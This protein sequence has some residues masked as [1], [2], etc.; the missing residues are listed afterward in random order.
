MTDLATQFHDSVVVQ[1][2]EFIKSERFSEAIAF[3]T[4]ALAREPADAEL[5]Y[6][7]GTAAFRSGDTATAKEAF[8]ATIRHDPSHAYAHYGLGLLDI[9]TGDLEQAGRRFQSALDADPSLLAARKQLADLEIIGQTHTQGQVPPPLSQQQPASAGPPTG[10]LPPG[11]ADQPYTLAELLDVRGR[12]RP[13][14]E[15]MAGPTVWS[16]RPAARSMTG[17][18]LAAI[19]LI[20]L[21][22]FLAD[23][24]T[25]LPPGVVREFF[26]ALWR[27]AAAV[28]WPAAIVIVVIALARMAT[29]R[30]V[31]REHRVEVFA[32]LLNRQHS[33]VWMHDIERPVLVQQNLW[34]LALGLGT[35]EINSTA[36]PMPKGRRRFGQPG[37]LLLAGLPIGVA[38]QVAGFLRS[39]VL[40]QRRRM[41]QNF[42]SAR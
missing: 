27:V 14:E 4:D 17:S 16:G 38:E 34:Q 3:L 21:P 33:A 22:A 26:A 20:V 6:L 25:G 1:V 29:R 7:L 41:V 31:L 23:T 2:A 9:D 24:A 40:W 19:A 32:G 28:S 10:P 42:V 37:R 5:H 15:T 13:D 18:L 12:D 30:Y 8:E 35:V 36:L 39:E 11:L